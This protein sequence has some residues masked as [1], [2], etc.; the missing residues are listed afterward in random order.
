MK[1]NLPVFVAFALAFVAALLVF[2]SVKAMQPTVPVVVATRNLSVGDQI[3]SS[4]VAVK[5]LPAVAVPE[6]A[7]R[8]AES[9]V[10]KVVAFGPVLSGE[11]VRNEHISDESSLY[12]ALRTYASPDWAAIELPSDTAIGMKGL[13][14]GDKVDIYGEVPSGN[15]TVVSLVSR[16][17]ILQNL[18]GS[19]KSEN[20]R[21]IV[22]VPAN[23]APAVADIV[24][25]GRKLTLVLPGSSSGSKVPDTSSST[26]AGGVNSSEIPVSNNAG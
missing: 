9:A 14:R 11:I 13:R 6:S 17:I 25:R 26:D 21:Y 20:K 7:L 10:G 23:Y 5:R 22:A 16:G 8:R 1:K 12:T 24:V 19:D 4:D 18:D 2:V 15:G 3:T